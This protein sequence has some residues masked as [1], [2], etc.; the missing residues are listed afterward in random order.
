MKL[1][2]IPSER[3]AQK[4]YLIRGQKVM[5]DSDLADL[6]NVKTFALNQAVKRNKDR[7]PRD[8]MF[9]LSPEE[10]KNLISQIVISSWGGRRHL[11]YAFT[12][13]GVAMLSSVLKSKRAVHVNILIIRAFVQ[14]RELLATQKNVTHKL[15]R[16]EKTLMEHDK[17]LITIYELINKLFEK[18]KEP[19]KQKQI[20]FRPR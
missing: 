5:L 15:V 20:G 11:P 17:H 6:Y 7:F 3:I 19:P 9:Q 2:I 18:P 1:S 16:I 4:I 8:F 14:L 13:Q 12:E 10:H